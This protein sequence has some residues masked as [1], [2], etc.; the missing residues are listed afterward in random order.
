VLWQPYSRRC[1]SSAERA[2]RHFSGQSLIQELQLASALP[3]LPVK[4]DS[5]KVARAHAVTPLPE[6]GKVLL[7]EMAP[8]LNWYVDELAAFPTGLHDDAVDSTTQALNYLREPGEDGYMM[9]LL[10]SNEA[11]RAQEKEREK[12]HQVVSDPR[13]NGGRRRKRADAGCEAR[14]PVV[15]LTH[16]AYCDGRGKNGGRSTSR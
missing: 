6:A 8:W 12:Q 2:A 4:V 16:T 1:F 11:Q 15:N 3:V 13:E 7:P 14:E 9:W 5:D 10:K